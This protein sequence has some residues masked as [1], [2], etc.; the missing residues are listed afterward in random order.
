MDPKLQRQVIE[1][2]ISAL[3]TLFLFFLLFFYLRAFFF[4]KIE[5][6]LGERRQATSGTRKA[7][8]ESLKRA[9][10]KA[11]EYEEKLRAARGEIYQ[12][13]EAVRQQWRDEQAATLAG[14]RERTATLLQE[15]KA[16]LDAQVAGARTALASDSEAL[17]EQIAKSI[18]SGRNN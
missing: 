3:P 7:A 4:S 17:A 16:A 8:D 11:A 9:E 1:L 10:A 18:L 14:V 2:V 5:R 12:E 15:A 6:A 13:Q